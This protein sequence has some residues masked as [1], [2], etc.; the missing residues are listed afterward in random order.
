MKG[1]HA[2]Q[3]GRILPAIAPRITTQ[4][5]AIHGGVLEVIAQVVIPL[6]AFKQPQRQGDKL[7]GLALNVDQISAHQPIGIHD[8]IVKGSLLGRG[9]RRA[10]NRCRAIEDRDD[11]RMAQD[12]LPQQGRSR[13]H[14][15]IAI[16][17]NPNHPNAI[18]PQ[19]INGL[20]QQ[21]IGQGPTKAPDICLRQA[22]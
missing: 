5:G 22:D 19:A 9:S 14:S 10:G 12:A 2:L 8:Q 15:L 16:E 20:D 11:L 6:A 17:I 13:I 4:P 3:A 7:G 21:G 18:G 1:Q